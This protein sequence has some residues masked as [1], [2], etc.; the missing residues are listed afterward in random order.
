M[1][2]TKK[3]LGQF[4]TE[5][6]PFDNELFTTWFDGLPVDK[7][8]L[9]PFAG[10]NNIVSFLKDKTQASWACFDIEPVNDESNTSGYAITENDSLASF[11][12][13]FDVCIT[14]PPYLEKSIAT[15]KGT[16]YPENTIYDNLYKDSIHL[17]LQNCKWV[18]AIIPA[19]FTSFKT[20][21]LLGR[22]QAVIVQDK[23][24]FKETTQPVCLALFGPDETDSISISVNG[25]RMDYTELLALNSMITPRKRLKIKSHD[26]E[27][28]IVGYL[29]D[30]TTRS[31]VFEDGTDHPPTDNRGRMVVKLGGVDKAVVD[32]ANRLLNQW[33]A[34]TQ[35]FF[36]S[37]ALGFDS[38]GKYRRKLD[39][40]TAK[41]IL[42]KAVESLKGE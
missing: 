2:N 18:A 7:P 17:A 30:T 11:P 31:V 14:N 29:L 27:G 41:L 19:T 42:A 21:S 22:L 35:S 40:R 37:P 6:S 32:E 25:L 33:R 34:A 15:R 36:M 13:G 28:S 3:E 8:F 23:Q 20:K 10:S 16:P 1:T 9:E 24:F 26:P 4:F 12:Q 39:I 5:E 38:R